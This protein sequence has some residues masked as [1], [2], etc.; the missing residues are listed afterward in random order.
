MAEGRG[1]LLERLLR[2]GVDTPPWLLGLPESAMSCRQRL[3][4]KVS[5]RLAAAVR[6][7][8]TNVGGCRDRSI[9]V[10]WAVDRCTLKLDVRQ[11]S[12]R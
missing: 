2:S 6:I 9:K 5:K 1:A 10:R 3:Q 8:W 4:T 7:W 11:S 12:R